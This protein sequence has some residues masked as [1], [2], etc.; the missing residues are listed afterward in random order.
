MEPCKT[1]ICSVCQFPKNLTDFPR[2]RH[3]KD[4]RSYRCLICNRSKNT[5][6]Y[7]ENREE[8][9]AYYLQWR[10]TFWPSETHTTYSQAYYL[11][12]REKHLQRCKIYQATHPHVMQVINTRRRARKRAAILNDLTSAQWREIQENQKHQCAYCG[13]RRKGKLTQDHITPLIKG[14]NHT[15]HNVIA[16][17][18]SCNS[19]K[20][21]KPPPIPVQ[22]FLLTLASARTAS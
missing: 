13:K 8:R 10:E 5:R 7:A 21:T 11:T 14:G 18:R 2:D 6:Y 12:T 4:G 22:P 17:C 1:K 3:S 16:V 20:G 9:R 19:R 15:L